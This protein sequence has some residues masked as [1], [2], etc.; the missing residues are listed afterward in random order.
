MGA[1]TYQAMYRFAS[2]GEPGDRHP[3]RRAEGRLF[4]HADRA[5]GVGELHPGHSGP[6]RSRTRHN[7][8]RA[9]SLRTLGSLTLRRSLLSAGL[10]DRFRV[11]VFPVITGSTGR[12]RIY[13]GYPDV[14]LETVDGR[15]RALC[16]RSGAAAGQRQRPCPRA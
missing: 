14:S 3:D 1:T 6:S 9:K 12:D 11:V 5:A 16:A 13:D 2:S 7:A 8:T 4:E 15:T 10:V